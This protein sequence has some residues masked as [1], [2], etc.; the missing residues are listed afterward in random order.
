[1]NGM[2]YSSSFTK[3]R[4]GAKAALIA[5]ANSYLNMSN[6]DFN[7]VYAFSRGGGAYIEGA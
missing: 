6:V 5:I 7:D 3:I 4:A 1:M 2:I